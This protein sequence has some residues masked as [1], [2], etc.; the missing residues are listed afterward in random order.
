MLIFLLAVIFFWIGLALA[1]NTIY[2][3][4][5]VILLILGLF[6]SIISA[7]MIVKIRKLDKKKAYE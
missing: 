2:V 1:I 5:G 7:I 6:G 4:L 3:G